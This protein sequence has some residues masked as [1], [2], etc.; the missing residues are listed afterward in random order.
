MFENIFNKNKHLQSNDTVSD[1]PASAAAAGDEAATGL[2]VEETE[3]W[4]ERIR[5]AASDDAALLQLA[6]QA[7]NVPLKLAAIEALAQEAS[8][9]QAMHDFRDHDKRLYRAA[10]SRWE[11]AS[12]KRTATEEAHALIAN[13]RA[14]LEQEVVPVNRVVDLDHAWAALHR[15]QLDAALLQ[16][17]AG[18][19]EQLGAKVRAQGEH[20]QALTRWLARVDSAMEGLRAILPG[21]AQGEIPPDGSDALAL[22]LL[23]LAQSAPQ[24]GDARCAEKTD[25]AN[26]LLALASSVVERA[27]FLHTLPVSGA[28]DEAHEKRIIEQWREF[29]EI[30]DGEL[31]TVL[32]HRFADWR[33]ASSGER[34]REHDALTAQEREQRAAKNKERMDALQRDV[35]AAEAAQAAGHLADL[36]RLLGAIDHVLK[37]G[38]VNASLTQRIESL[39]REQ[40]R[41]HDWQRWSGAQGREQLAAEALALA[42]EVKA[43]DGKVAIKPHGEA[44]EKLRERW[45]ELDKLGAASNQS[46]WLAFDGALKAAYVP[47]AAHL[48]KL[49]AARE[50]NLAAREKIIEGL[51][52]AAAKYFPAA[53]AEQSAPSPEPT[54]A[55]PDWR[56]I[57]HALES[58]QMVWRKL[59][60]V[61]HTVPR[62]ALQGAKAVT[63][64][65]AAACAAL[66]APLK[67]AY[68]EARR[69]REQLIAGAKELAGSAQSRD[70]VD[71]V[72]RL[73]TQWQSVAKAM[74]LPR[75]DEN[76]LWMEFKKATDA[77]FAAKD[78]ARAASEAEFSAKIKAREA[79]IEKVAELAR[80]N[81][82]QEIKRGMADGDAAWRAAPEVPRSHAAKLDARYRAARDAATQRIS[83]LALHATQARYDALIAKMALCDE[84]EKLLDA[85]DSN[86]TLTE[87]QAMELE[88]RWNAV[89]HFPDVWKAKLDARFAGL[90]LAK[91]GKGAAESL[92]DILL[93]L[94][95]A[96]GIDSPEEFLAARQMLK[97][98]AL[99]AAMEGRQATVTTPAD[100]ERWLLDAGAYPRP[101][102]VS[103]ARLEKIIAAVRRRR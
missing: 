77:I 88:A 3:V 78:A 29:P 87:A 51:V 57:S 80:G 28:G 10:K 8:L 39:R 61:E 86:G 23:E 5:A 43:K 36:T 93:N 9:K 17:F 90:P 40:R 13:A 69:Q 21:V 84:R 58:A 18:L 37:R 20:V 59:G 103:R 44:I 6:N 102:A 38:P 1:E 50:E 42:E 47:V 46:V 24:A 91:P 75:R 22:S 83:A 33:N 53:A 56:G 66:D 49:R 52:Q 76:A 41:L 71:K 12:G 82:A 54:D 31:H 45:K 73:Q 64:R 79:V 97:M 81:T 101:D 15:E 98:R 16:E 72:R 68:G 74:P 26:R 27:K 48:E 25:A 62:K 32:A 94:E 92:P 11:A 96:C 4:Q 34:Q 7:P 99:K 95:V 63:A 67:N 100:M 60:P 14:L 89:E 30:T 70:V 19:S 35:D 65:Y 2:S 85:P 55:K